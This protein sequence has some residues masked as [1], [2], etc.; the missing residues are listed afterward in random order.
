MQS[1]AEATGFKDAELLLLMPQLRKAA[2]VLTR[3]EDKSNDLAQDTVE[4][5]LSHRHQF[6]PD[7]PGSKLM[8]WAARIM[9]NQWVTTLRNKKPFVI[10][11]SGTEFDY[12]A[13]GPDNQHSSLLFNDLLT[14]GMASLG[15]PIAMTFMMHMQ[16]PDTNYAVIAA[17]LG[18]PENTVKTRIRR[19]R[20][21]LKEYA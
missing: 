4:L 3:S 9:R 12:D 16:D 14:R 19:A 11:M 18:V 21:A 5:M 7:R 20:Q 17:N 6:Y 8:S 2:M 15:K 1:P 13:P 10:S